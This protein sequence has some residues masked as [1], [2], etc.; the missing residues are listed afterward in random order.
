MCSESTRIALHRTSPVVG[1]EDDLIGI[2]DL[3]GVDLVPAHNM[4]GSLASI[5]G[6]DVGKPRNR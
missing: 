2:Q 3:I 4:N 6:I 1:M 5:H